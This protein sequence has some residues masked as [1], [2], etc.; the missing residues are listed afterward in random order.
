MV[1][2]RNLANQQELTTSVTS[3]TTSSRNL[4]LSSLFI[5][6]RINGELMW[7]GL[8]GGWATRHLRAFL[9]RMDVSAWVMATSGPSLCWPPV[10]C[11]VL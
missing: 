11:L 10:L 1:V 6:R 4:T 2:S 8:G 3:S 5:V 9:W 7:P